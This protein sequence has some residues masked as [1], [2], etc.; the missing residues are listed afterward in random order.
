MIIL[1]RF[2]KQINLMGITLINVTYVLEIKV[3]VFF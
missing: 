1:V 2:I 3:T